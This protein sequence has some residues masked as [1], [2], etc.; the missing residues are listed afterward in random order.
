MMH[1]S[2]FK[3]VVAA[4]LLAVAAPGAVLVAAA[5]AFADI[6]AAKALVDGA[7]AAGKVG[8]LNTGYLGFVGAADSGALKA[9]VDE[10]NAGRKQVYAQAAQKNGV[11]AEAAGIAAFNTVILPKLASGDYY[12]DNSGKWARK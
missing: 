5:P 7:K 3:A 8:E 6:A 9:A 2:S 1:L 4:G 12:Q 10:I 11:S